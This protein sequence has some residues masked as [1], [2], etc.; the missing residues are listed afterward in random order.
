M[1]VWLLPSAGGI[2]GKM[3]LCWLTLVCSAAITALR[4]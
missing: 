4:H 1:L 2:Q 3:L